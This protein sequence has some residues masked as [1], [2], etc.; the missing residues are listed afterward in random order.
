MT[1]LYIDN[2]LIVNSIQRLSEEEI[3]H[4]KVLRIRVGETVTIVNG[5][6]QS[7]LAKVLSQHEVRL[8]DV[9]E[10]APPIHRSIIIQAMTESTHLDL[11]VEKGCELGVTDFWFFI[12]KKSKKL[13]LSTNK[14]QRLQNLLIS[15]LKQSGRL[16]LP[17]ISFFDTL[18]QIHSIP[19]HLYLADPTGTPPNLPLVEDC[20]IMIG[21]ESGF[22]NDEIHFITKTLGAKKISLSS[23]ILRAETASIIG[24]YLLSC[25]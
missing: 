21:P 17:E 25:R 19:K 8:I 22:T 14:R 15:A 20:A 1:R 10:S 11:L 6:G 16:Y 2:P 24:A 9:K 7:A 23:N 5:K 4:F 13:T 18:C 12:A 3:R